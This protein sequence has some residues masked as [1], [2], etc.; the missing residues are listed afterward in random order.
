M[1]RDSH[2]TAQAIRMPVNMGA[3][4][5]VNASRRVL[6]NTYALLGMTLAFSAAVAGTAMSLNLPAPGMLLT[7]V[8]FYGLF[9]LVHKLSNSGWG[10]AA[11]FGLTGF[12]G[13]TLG[14][15]LNSVLQ[16]PNGGAVIT[17]AL[18]ATAVAFIGLSAVSLTTKKDFSFMGKTLFVGTLIAMVLGLGA[19]F[20]EVPALSLAV[21]AMVVLLMSGMILFE[22]S[23]IVNG[24]ETNYLMATV[25]LFV[26]IYN[27]FTSLLM[28]FGIGSR[29]E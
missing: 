15:L 26:S 11:V 2:S 28:L 7:L 25:S 9:F 19:V 18:G 10:V 21:S 16:M 13:Y 5:D 17:N 6:R 4:V 3:V 29:D 23:R 14:P 20:F 8:G 1:N 27:M 24:G 22:T 12:M